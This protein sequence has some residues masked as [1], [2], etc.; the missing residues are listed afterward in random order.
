MNPTNPYHE[1]EMAKADLPRSLARREN[2]LAA[3]EV[4]TGWSPRIDITID[5]EG[6]ITWLRMEARTHL[7]P[8]GGSRVLRGHMDHIGRCV[9]EVE[10][11][12]APQGTTLRQR[13]Q[14]LAT[15]L[16][17]L[18]HRRRPEGPRAMLKLAAHYVADN[19]AGGRQP[20]RL[21][22]RNALALLLVRSE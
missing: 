5:A 3:I 9:F 21:E 19:P 11:E 4:L 10:E 20:A 16:P 17:I 8:G 18:L 22:V 2:A 15:P 14:S 6:N 13:Q 12:A 1:A 7:S